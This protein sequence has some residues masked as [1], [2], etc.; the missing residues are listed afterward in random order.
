MH[1]RTKLIR[2]NALQAYLMRRVREMGGFAVKITSP[3][4]RGIPDVLIIWR[5]Y[6]LFVEVK[7]HLKS[8]PTAIQNLTIREMRDAGGHVT[9][10]SGKDQADDYLSWLQRL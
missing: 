1:A 6:V 5:K 4:R 3:S 8:K 2:E 10:V 9:L 7:M